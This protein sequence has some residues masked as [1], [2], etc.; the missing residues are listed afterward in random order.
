MFFKFLF[1][2]FFTYAHKTTA[3]WYTD[4]M[5]YDMTCN[6]SMWLENWWV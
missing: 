3:L 4:T 1:E 5:L 6:Y 2:A